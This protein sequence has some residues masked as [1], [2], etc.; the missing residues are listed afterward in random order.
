MDAMY[1]LDHTSEKFDLICFDIFDNDRIP[2]K[3]LSNSI[4]NK[5]KNRLTTNGVV[6]MNMLYHLD[7]DIEETDSYYERIFSP[8]FE[9]K[10]RLF[11][12][13]NMMLFGYR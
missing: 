11:V 10:K 1:Y 2:E 12:R 7:K 8:V 5:V 6:I 13:N 4:I 9:V 3:F